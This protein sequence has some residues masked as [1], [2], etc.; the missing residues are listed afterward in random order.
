M[1]PAAKRRKTGQLEEIVFD[2][3]A[4]QDYLTGFHKRKEARKK[5]AQETAAKIEKEER[6]QARKQVCTI[7]DR[8]VL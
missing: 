2:L 7:V 3:A 5:H 6:V 4:R 1:A 8:F